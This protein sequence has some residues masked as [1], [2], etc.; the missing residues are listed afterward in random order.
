MLTKKECDTL[1]ADYSAHNMYR[2]IINMQ[3]YRFGIG[4][5]KYFQYP[6]PGIITELRENVYPNIA[7]VGA[8]AR[9]WI[10]CVYQNGS[11][12]PILLQ[13]RIIKIC[14]YAYA[15]K[16]ATRQTKIPC[17]SCGEFVPGTGFASYTLLCCYDAYGSLFFNI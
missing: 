13:L 3:R 9:D 2:K 6:L 4:E 12:Y 1:I 16:L 5:Y 17:T 11:S 14:L 10:N 8:S 15:N 7:P